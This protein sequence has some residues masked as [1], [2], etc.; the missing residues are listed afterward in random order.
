LPALNTSSNLC[1]VQAAALSVLANRG[2]TALTDQL[3]FSRNACL[4]SAA[5]KPALL[6]S[7]NSFVFKKIV[8]DYFW[9][10]LWFMR[11]L[12]PTM[13]LLGRA[14]VPPFERWSQAGK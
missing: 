13:N 7:K 12:K 11:S 8:I 14:P 6:K 3:L 4:K 5:L 1:K 2:S 10:Q 9:P